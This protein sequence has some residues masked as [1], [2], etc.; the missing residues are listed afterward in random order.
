V[1]YKCVMS[2]A[3][4]GADSFLYNAGRRPIESDWCHPS[5]G[6]RQWYALFYV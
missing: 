3:S 5:C 6:P 1:H 2:L 4:A